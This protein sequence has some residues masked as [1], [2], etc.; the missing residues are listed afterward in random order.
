MSDTEAAPVAA[1]PPVAEPVAAAAEA[2]PAASADDGLY[3]APPDHVEGEVDDVA[4]LVNLNEDTLLNEL[5]IRYSKD[6][7]YTYVSDILIAVN[8]FKQLG[9]YGPEV[10]AKY[11]DHVRGELPPHVYGVADMCYHNI[12]KM[13]QSQ[14]CVI[15][16]ESG[17]GKTESAKFA[18]KQILELCSAGQEGRSLEDRIIQVSPLLEA[19]GNAQ[20]VLNDNSSR[21]GKYTRLLF[22]KEGKVL[23]VQLSTYLLEKSRVVEQADGE[24]CFHCFYYIFDSPGKEKY[25]LTTPEEFGSVKGNLWSDNKAMYEEL[26][27]AMEVVGFNAEEQETL[28]LILAAVIH[29]SNIEFDGTE[30]AY[31]REGFSKTALRNAAVMLDTDPTALEDALLV[32]HSVLRGEHIQRNHKPEQAYDAR[33]ALAKTLYSRLFLYI[34]TKTNQMLAPGLHSIKRSDR[35]RPISVPAPAYEIGVLDI[36]G[37]ENF[38]DNSF[39][40]ICINVAHENLQFFF[41]KH[42][43]KL[44]LEEYEREGIDGKA[45]TFT[46]NGPLLAMFFDKPLGILSILDSECT[47][48]KATDTTFRMKIDEK[49]AEH[50]FY[51]VV[52]IDQGHPAFRIK[53]FAAVVEYNATN[54]L[55]KNRD[56]LA[57][58]LLGCMQSCGRD[59]V[60]DLFNSEVTS[61]GE[62]KLQEGT[63]KPKMHRGSVVS[64]DGVNT[65]PNRRTPSLSTQFKD[66][67][68]DLLDKMNDCYPHFVRCIKPNTLQQSD[69]FEDEYIKVQLAYT[70]VLEATRIRQEG[71]AWRPTFLD[72]VQRFKILGF[73]TTKLHMVSNT[74]KAALQIINCVGLTDFHV[75]KTKLFLKYYHAPQM[76]NLLREYFE[77]VT[78]SQAAVRAF[79]ARRKYAK[80]QRRKAAT[81][82]ERAAMEEQERQEAEARRIAR[83]AKEAEERKHTEEVA[84]QEALAAAASAEAEALRLKQQEIELEQAKVA[85]LSAEQQEKLRKWQ[86][87]RDAAELA[88]REAAEKAER[89]AKEKEEAEQEKQQVLL[90]RQASKKRHEKEHSELNA[91]IQELEAKEEKLRQQ[92]ERLRI[93]AEKKNWR[94]PEF[95]LNDF[96]KEATGKPL[97]AEIS[98]DK[99]CM[100]GYLEKRGQIN[101]AYQK[102]YFVLDL[103]NKTLSYFKNQQAASASEKAKGSVPLDDILRVYAP[104][105]EK[106]NKKSVFLVETPFRTYFCRTQG[107]AEM[108]AWVEAINVVTPGGPEELVES[109]LA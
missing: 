64:E 80:L 38:A 89:E 53:H 20:T 99:L 72:F 60:K 6:N 7:I 18:I 63:S 91:R 13:K 30:A 50:G 35:G 82:A 96:I 97:P 104:P 92:K 58:G 74:A 54:F 79:L 101:T 57:P 29:L 27:K 16:G 17:A 88:A 65:T 71:Y 95:A 10:M 48:P 40:Q 26:V 34:V 28:H 105:P 94:K 51:E 109:M 3:S 66:S 84:V 12:F 9:I 106:S 2:A 39:E 52:K 90:Q 76:E 46:D 22:D 24:R 49:Y 59:V 37:F 44:E 21:F 45:V 86:E 62:L 83:E 81:E 1:D 102:R 85:A 70:G 68:G 19:F 78:R 11:D 42:T 77:K 107:T 47:F 69:N 8:P 36:F 56:N 73:P 93:E 75:G 32:T 41:N 5:K 87:E 103:K 15:S 67:L 100:K 14:C 98:V 43:F 61:T 31:V 33:D 108:Q 55:E 25:N 23:G 4:T